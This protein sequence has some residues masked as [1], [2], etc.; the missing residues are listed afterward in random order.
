VVSCDMRMT[1]RP[2]HPRS[3]ELTRVAV[4][5]YESPALVPDY[6]DMIMST[7][8]ATPPFKPHKPRWFFTVSSP[9]IK[10]TA[11]NLTSKASILLH[12]PSF[13]LLGSMVQ[14]VQNLHTTLGGLFKSGSSHLLT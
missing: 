13:A 12:G 14:L 3:W 8:A 7:S 11:R 10:G 6:A 1:D 5:K 9:A 2:L 4:Q